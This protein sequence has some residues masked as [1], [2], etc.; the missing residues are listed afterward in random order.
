VGERDAT[1]KEYNTFR[2]IA[3]LELHIKDLT[4]RSLISNFEQVSSELKLTKT[5]LHVPRL[6]EEMAK[7]SY[8]PKKMDF[9]GLLGMMGKIT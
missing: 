2:G 3:E 1:Q 7:G 9:G 6:R 5:L 8:E 4:E